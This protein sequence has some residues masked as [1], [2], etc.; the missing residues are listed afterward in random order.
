MGVRVHPLFGPGPNNGNLA[1]NTPKNR[2]FWRKYTKKPGI[3][4][5]IHQK[6]GYLD[7]GQ[8]QKTGYLDQGQSQKPVIWTRAKPV[9]WTREK[10]VIWT[11][12]KNRFLL[13]MHQKTGFYSK[14]HQNPGFTQNPTKANQ[15]WWTTSRCLVDHFEVPGGPLRRVILTDFR[16]IF[17]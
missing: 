2:V 15:A 12:A 17:D 1:R 16:L 10:P 8:S 13:K 14:M 4:A 5:K 7:Q 9:I 11:R 6:T 3:L